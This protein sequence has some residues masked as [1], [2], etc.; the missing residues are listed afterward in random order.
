MPRHTADNVYVC[1]YISIW[2][3]SSGNGATC[4]AHQGKVFSAYLV[5]VL[6]KRAR[7]GRFMP[8]LR[9]LQLRGLHH[10]LNPRRRPP[11]ARQARNGSQSRSL[12]ARAKKRPKQLTTMRYPSRA[13]KKT[14]ISSR[15]SLWPREDLRERERLLL[16]ATPRTRTRILRRILRQMQLSLLG[17]RSP[18]R[19]HRR[20]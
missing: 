2:L 20:Q 12:E 4:G 7:Q 5:H 13:R 16:E 9:G 18:Q 14:S 6:T 11:Q 17:S 3:L 15:R 19:V 1:R 8:L 10:R